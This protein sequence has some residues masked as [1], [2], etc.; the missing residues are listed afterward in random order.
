MC[1]PYNDTF[2]ILPMVLSLVAL[3][4]SWVWW[5]TFLI[6]ILGVI[7]YQMCWC[8]RQPVASLYLAGIFAGCSSLLS[9][10]VGFYALLRF[11]DSRYCNPY[12]LNSNGVLDDDDYFE[13]DFIDE[14]D[15]DNCEEKTWAAIAFVCGTLWAVVAGCTLFFV[16]SG[17][18]ATF[19]VIHGGTDNRSPTNSERGSAHRS[20][21]SSATTSTPKASRPSAP[22]GEP[23]IAM[24]PLV[25]E[26][27]NDDSESKDETC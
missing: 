24:V 2:V 17:R 10:L 21:S 27:D 1:M 18:H 14:Y 11:E 7:L 25:V 13:D 19:E 16:W 3:L 23:P 22:E 20:S 12:I 8:C 4:I 15:Y 6:S 26:S 9:V 5:V